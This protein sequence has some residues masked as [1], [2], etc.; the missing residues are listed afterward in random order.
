[1]TNR[2]NTMPVILLALISILT[3]AMACHSEDRPNE[4]PVSGANRNAPLATG[5]A[6]GN[7]QGDA[8]GTPSEPKS[9]EPGDASEDDFEGTAGPTEK[10]RKGQYPLVLREVRTAA[11]PNFDRVVFEFEG[12]A[13]PGYKVEYLVKPAR[14]CGSGD[15]AAVEGDGLLGV[16]FTP[17]QA[18]TDSG[19]ASV[20]ERERHPNLKTLKELE[21]IC[22]FEAEVAWVLGLSA[23]NRYRVVERANPAR[24]VVDIKH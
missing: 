13:L 11:H 23:P 19:Q 18:H 20:K 10:R 1:M 16:T 8:G 15:A 9:V 12:D 21:I 24:L 7:R 6:N 22:D 5:N 4:G 3:F 17:A 2:P 14:Q